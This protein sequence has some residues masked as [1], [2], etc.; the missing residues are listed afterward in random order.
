MKP[1]VHI[2]PFTFGS[3]A[4]CMAIG[5]LVCT[6]ILELNLKRHNFLRVNAYI[7]ALALG[8]L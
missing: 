5:L 4:I 7:L 2:G 3:Y 1:Y 8:N 6:H